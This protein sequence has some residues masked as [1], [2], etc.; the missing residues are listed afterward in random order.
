MLD[1][2]HVN[3][4]QRKVVLVIAL[5][6]LVPMLITGILSA[7]WIA[8]R[9][10]TSIEGWLRESAQV[11]ETTIEDLHRNARLLADVLFEATANRPRLQAGHSPIPERLRPL[12]RELGISLVQ[13]YGEKGELLYTSQPASL[14]T[15]WQHGQDTAVVRV[16]QQDKN[17][18][19]AITIVRIPRD[20]RRHYRLVLGTLFD[21]ELLNRLSRQSGLKT[22]L[23]YPQDGD[24][25]KAFSEEGRPMKLHL[26]Q[27]A[28]RRLN[29]H[30]SYYSAKAENGRYWGLYSPIVDANGGVEAI[31]FSG[32]ARGTGAQLL[33][34]QSTLALAIILLGTLLAIATG[35]FI[36]R[37]VVRPVEYLHQGVMKVAAQDFRAAIPI[38]SRDELGELARA[39]NS[40][41]DTLRDARDQQR[42]EFQRDKMTALGEL[43]LALAHEIRNPIG[44]INT[45][46]KLLET[47]DDA[48]KRAEL[49]RVIREESLRLDQF[50]KDF[51]QLARHRR[52]EFSAIDPVA[53]L[54]QALRTMLAGRDNIDVERHYGHGALRIQADPELLQ[55]AW[56]NLVRNALEAMGPKPGSLEAGSQVLG[57]TLVVYLHDSGPGIPLEA[58]TRLFE[59]FYSTKDQGSGL[60]LTLA[61]TLVEANGASLE[62]IPGNWQGARFAMRFPLANPEET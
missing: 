35:Y 39:F 43:S 56:A 36:S 61:N 50:L 45:A 7:S 29:R 51:Q 13:V 41:A 21:K 27:S 53:P 9:F 5:I 14:A 6:I 20:S 26:P 2:R 59:P 34:D 4:L 16:E 15:Y 47:S 8:N 31:L 12:A 28:L 30:Q 62:L 10:D 55:Q 44:V 33:T 25:T 60:G 54:D 58:M 24:F 1:G 37:I 38:H 11:D 32:Q 52:P 17:L 3:R 23:F 57:D 48:A 42:R 18:L 49:R 40:M 22:R 19:A 46:S